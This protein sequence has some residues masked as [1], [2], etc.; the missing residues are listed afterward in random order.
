MSSGPGH[1]LTTSGNL[2]LVTSSHEG[3]VRLNI[4]GSPN[5]YVN[6]WQPCTLNGSYNLVENINGVSIINVLFDAL[7]GSEFGAHGGIDYFIDPALFDQS[8]SLFSS[9]EQSILLPVD[10]LEE[11]LGRYYRWPIIRLAVLN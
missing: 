5:L 6:T 11:T 9:S 2:D 3:T 1:T 7:M 8:I 10:Q 4:A